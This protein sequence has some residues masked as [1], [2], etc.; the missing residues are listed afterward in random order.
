MDFIDS[1]PCRAPRPTRR[2]MPP[3]PAAG[4]TLIELLVTTVVAALLAAVAVPS[5]R[6]LILSH[7]MST[8]V[9]TLVTHL[10]LGRSEAVTRN[11]QVV[12]CK[13]ADGHTC[14]S[15]AHWDEGWILFVDKD[16]DEQ[17]DSQ[18]ALLR[19]HGPLPSGLSLRYAGFPSNRY[20]TFEPIGISNANGSFVFCDERGA[21][22][23]RAVV[24]SKTARARIATRRSNGDPL[25]C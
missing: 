18:D 5:M 14:D 24:V 9:N 11:R 25:T 8:Q 1:I 19:V 15:L 2:R 10:Y 16:R 4:Y 22:G 13:S 20:M 6:T 3:R 23:A 17:R 7:R 21:A 12:I